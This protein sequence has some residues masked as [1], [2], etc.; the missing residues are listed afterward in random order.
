MAGTLC[1]YLCARVC[2]NVPLTSCS[3]SLPHSHSIRA[4]MSPS[5][6]ADTSATR[7]TRWIR[8]GDVPTPPKPPPCRPTVRPVGLGPGAL[9]A[10]GPPR[11]H[12]PYIHACMHTHPQSITTESL[13]GSAETLATCASTRFLHPALLFFCEGRGYALVRTHSFS[14]CEAGTGAVV[15]GPGRVVFV[16]AGA[17]LREVNVEALPMA[18]NTRFDRPEGGGVG[19]RSLALGAMAARAFARRGWWWWWW[20]SS[21]LRRIGHAPGSAVAPWAP[22]SFVIQAFRLA[23]TA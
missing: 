22:A 11:H 13:W 16:Q 12:T 23:A 9:L 7:V 3:L 20:W 1:V 2:G 10:P 14:V 19:G 21:V 15:I 4:P 5:G 18:Q 8:V 17:R 6:G